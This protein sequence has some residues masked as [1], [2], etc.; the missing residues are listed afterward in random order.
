M[1][2]RS[3]AKKFISPKVE[4]TQRLTHDEW[5]ERVEQERADREAM[6]QE[7]RDRKEEEAEQK[8]ELAEKVRYATVGSS[9]SSPNGCTFV[10]DNHKRVLY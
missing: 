9:V 2:K 1:K 5:L 4:M 8:A 6:E 10:C 7:E 3:P